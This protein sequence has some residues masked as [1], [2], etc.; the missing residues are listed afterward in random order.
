M[1]FTLLFGSKKNKVTF[2]FERKGELANK[3]GKLPLRKQSLRKWPLYDCNRRVDSNFIQHPQSIPCSFPLYEQSVALDKKQTL[4]FAAG[5]IVGAETVCII[6]NMESFL[7]CLCCGEITSCPAWQRSDFGANKQTTEEEK[8]FP[9]WPNQTHTSKT[10]SRPVDWRCVWV[11]GASPCSFTTSCPSQLVSQESHSCF[12]YRRSTLRIFPPNPQC[13]G[14]RSLRRSDGGESGVRRAGWLLVC[15]SARLWL[16]LLVLDA[17]QEK[18]ELGGGQ[19]EG[20]G[21]PQRLT[22]LKSI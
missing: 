3:R 7:R 18:R 10:L 5:S 11:D 17:Q 15:E 16:P 1:K 4:Y 2:V 9:S 13:P 6:S 19:D 8:S 21:R 12:I 22:L 14:L 20:S